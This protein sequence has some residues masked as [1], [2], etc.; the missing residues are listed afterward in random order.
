MVAISDD[1]SPIDMGAIYQMLQELHIDNDLIAD[2]LEQLS[3]G[4]EQVD[5]FEPVQVPQTRFGTLTNGSSLGHHTELARRTVSRDILTMLHDLQRFDDG[6]V[7]FRKG[8][9]V[10]DE[11]ARADLDHIAMEIGSVVSATE[12]GFEK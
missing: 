6:V 5:G 11:H 10:A 2:I 7:T 1:G 9:N 8:F 4:M 12:E 3:L